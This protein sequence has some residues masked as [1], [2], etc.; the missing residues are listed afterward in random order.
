MFTQNYVNIHADLPYS[1]SKLSFS[2]LCVSIIL[3]ENLVILHF[4]HRLYLGV[5]WCY[6]SFV[7]WSWWFFDSQ[8]FKNVPS[9]P[10]QNE[11]SFYLNRRQGWSSIQISECFYKKLATC[12]GRARLASL[13]EF[14]VCASRACL[15]PLSAPASHL[16]VTFVCNILKE[17]FDCNLTSCKRLTA[18]MARPFDYECA[19]GVDWEQ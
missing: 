13:L 7:I 16:P 4:H 6:L 15:E 14:C 12:D 3:R 5:A 10:L 1:F 9:F 8:C 19:H 2:P 17:T 18:T 11:V